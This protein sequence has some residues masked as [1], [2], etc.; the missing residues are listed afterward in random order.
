[1]NLL[2]LLVARTLPF[3]PKSLVGRV[4]R[5]YIAGSSL[6]DAVRVVREL[7]AQ[8]TMATVDVL[9]EF[10]TSPADVD[11]TLGVYEQTLERLHR[12][13]IDSNI[14]VKLTSIGLL[15]DRDRC[16]QC[17]RRLVSRAREL[18]NW[19]R[20]DMED[21]PCTDDTL[22]IFHRVREE[23]PQSVGIVLQSY[24]RRT[25]ADAERLAEVGANVRVC[26]GIY[27][28][29]RSIAYKNRGLD[30]RNYSDTVRLLLSRGSYV[31]IATHDEVVVW[32]TERVIRELGLP[33]DRYEFQML[34][35]VDEQLRT[36]IVAAGHRM[37]VYVPFGEAWYAYSIRRLKENPS[38]AG[39]ILRATLG[40][41]PS[42]N[43]TG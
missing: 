10:V 29:P 38:I 5:P 34:L 36:L 32:E 24:L 31:G 21:S 15:L 6:D 40:M 2:N 30:Q 22:D 28:E 3:V 12:E 14:S 41:G 11:R 13:Q 20:I 1:M 35:G 17:V 37:R 18:D 9:G 8:G 25:L 16:Y 19:V 4:S 7:N 43:G 26:K 42:E 33:P 27:V 39:H 23:F